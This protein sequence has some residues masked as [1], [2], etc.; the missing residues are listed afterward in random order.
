MANFT[1]GRSS[2]TP[3]LYV[4]FTDT[5][6]NATSWRW[7]LGGQAWPTATCPTVVFRHPGEY[8]VALTVTNA[9]GRSTMT[10]NLSVIGAAPRG[11]AGSA[12]SVV[13]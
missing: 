12:V 8:A 11:L 2:G 5:S 13:G 1:V 10:G 6:T 4:R 9:F 3:P 7:D